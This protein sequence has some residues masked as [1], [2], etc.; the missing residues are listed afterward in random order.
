MYAA[1]V[2]SAELAHFL[3]SFGI[4]QLSKVRRSGIVLVACEYKF[5]IGRKGCASRTVRS[6]ELTDWLEGLPIPQARRIVSPDLVG[7]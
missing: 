3:P 6:T 7:Q 2:L 5:P 1:V 4:P